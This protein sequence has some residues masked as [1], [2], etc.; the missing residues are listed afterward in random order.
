MGHSH[1]HQHGHHHG[2][3]HGHADA[4]SRN[5]SFAF[6]LNF[7]FA[8]LEFAGGY[9]TNSVAIVAD[10]IHDLGDSLALLS[11]W[12]LQRVSLKSSDAAYNFGYRRYSIFGALIAGIILVVGSVLLI[13]E[14]WE[15]LQSP[16]D[17]YV[18]GMLL[19]AFLG[20]AVNGA[21]A[22]RLSKGVGLN[23]RIV[24][25]HMM[26]DLLGWLAVLIVSGVLWFQ[27]TWTILDPIL[28]LGVAVLILW[29]AFR[30]LRSVFKILLQGRP[31]R[32]RDEDL[33]TVFVDLKEVKGWHSL[34]AWTLD[35]ESHVMDLHVELLEDLKL[36]ELEPLRKKIKERLRAMDFHYAHI[37]FEFASKDCVSGD[38]ER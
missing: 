4:A 14:A 30:S 29:N 34:K 27:P 23:Q 37:E 16:E 26:E 33:E 6:A 2:H 18:P 31:E 38:C 13:G 19:F 11:A 9:W 10:A 24:F 5:L 15:R 1:H 28:S 35:G 25:W 17:V 21:A 3:H 12:V 22:W 32:F 7:A 20:I 8:L 36:S